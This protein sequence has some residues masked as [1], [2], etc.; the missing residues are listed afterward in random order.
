M[1]VIDILD[2]L[3]SIYGQPTPSALEANDRIFRS[4]TSAANAPEVL[5]RR[6]EECAEIALLGQNPYTDKQL[7]TNMI[8]LLLTTG[9]YIRAFE[10]WDQL[11]EPA[12]TWIE[13]RRRS[14]KPSNEGST[15]QPPPQATK[16][17]PPPVHSSRMRLVPSPQTIRMMIQPTR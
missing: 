16:D 2:Q 12:K 11:T 17:M 8:H 5:F 9:L 13:L 10:D 14:R 3:S 4:P 1:R 7:I 6:I 15:Q